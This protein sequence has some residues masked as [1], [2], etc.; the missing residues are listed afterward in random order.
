MDRM[1][2]TLKK[3]QDEEGERV[4]DVVIKRLWK[5]WGH[6]I[7]P[8]PSLD[9]MWICFIGYRLGSNFITLEEAEN[10]VNEY[11]EDKLKVRATS[12]NTKTRTL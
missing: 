7:D 12:E 1:R 4:L 8:E 10:E 2:Q 5:K 3:L 6:L 11:F 9:M